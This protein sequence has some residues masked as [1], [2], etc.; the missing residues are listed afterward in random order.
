MAPTAPLFSIVV[1]T[2]SRPGK[3]AACLQ[4]V[5]GLCY[6]RDRFEV[7]VVDDGSERTPADL[8]GSFRDRLD[9]KL[10]VQPHAGPASARNAGAARA[11]G[12]FLAFTDD[13]CLPASDWLKALAGRFA[14]SPD[15]VIG[16]C[17]L[18]ALPRNWYSTASQLLIHYLYLYYNTEPDRAL[19]FASNNLA[20]PADRF[21]AIGGFDTCYVRAAAE[22][23]EFC[24]RWL[25][26]G[27]QMIYAP[28]VLVYH[29]HALTWRTFWRQHFNYGRGAFQFH[30]ARAQ[31][32]NGRLRLEP[33]SFYVRLLRYP[34]SQ[35]C[36]A[37]SLRIV[38]LLGVSQVA[39]AAGFLWESR[40]AR[41]R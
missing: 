23:R 32:G 19:F 15:C 40:L 37:Q 3:L 31:G 10:I 20:L 7:I 5:A 16:G 36:E 24:D 8:V 1:P 33:R 11:R 6:S 39:N 4:A 21:R 25:R 38:A 2:Y 12:E 17:T 13:D 14:A 35:S 26:H 22:D 29:A 9:V 30:Q 41:Q 18:N 34:L 27:Y 28:E